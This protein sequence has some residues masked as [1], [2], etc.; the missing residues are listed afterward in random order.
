MQESRQENPIQVRANKQMHALTH[1]L[2]TSRPATML[3]ATGPR[4]RASMSRL[5]GSTA[6][7]APTM[8]VPWRAVCCSSILGSITTPQCSLLR[9]KCP[10][11]FVQVS[12][13]RALLRAGTC[14]RH[15]RLLRQSCRPNV[16]IQIPLLLI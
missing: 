15:C 10:R 12:Y 13:L 3:H 11:N 9:Q 16:H 8:M 5:V 7:S 1:L 4:S 2:R 14:C 6:S